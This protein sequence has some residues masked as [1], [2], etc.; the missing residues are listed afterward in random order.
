MLGSQFR[1]QSLQGI[2]T[3]GLLNGLLPC[4]MVYAALFG[5]LA[6]QHVTL[7]SLYMALF[8]IRSSHS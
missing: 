5:A 3:I 1:N 2:F 4:G 6:M 7:G 8:G